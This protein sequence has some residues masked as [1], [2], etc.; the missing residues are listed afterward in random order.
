LK[1]L[2]DAVAAGDPIHAVICGSGINQD[3]A[4]NGIT[5]PNGAAQEK[6]IS[7]VYRKFGIDP[8]RIGYVE[9]HGTGTRLG[10][11]VEANA[12]IRAFRGFTSKQGYCALG[13]AK[14]HIGHTAAA[15]GV[16]GLIKVILSL[17][18]RRIPALPGLETVNPLIE[19]EGSPFR[20]NT[21]DEEWKSDGGPRMAALNSFGHSG[22]NAHLVIRE[23]PPSGAGASVPIAEHG[24]LFPLSAKTPEQLREKAL[25]LLDWLR[26]PELR[27][28]AAGPL[29]VAYT[30]QTGREPMEERV[31]FI[32][33]SLD[34]LA[35]KL[36]AWLEGASGLE[37][38][39]RGTVKRKP[40]AVGLFGQD[41]E[42]LEAVGKWIA[43]NKLSKL[44][45]LWV[46]G[47][48]LDWDPLYPGS[49][50][51][52]VRL[53]TYPFAQERY[54]VGGAG[55][56]PASGDAGPMAP[57]AADL[58]SVEDILKDVDEDAIGTEQAS[59]L[60]KNLV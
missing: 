26:S 5:A 37:G 45:E 43:R 50:P 27:D 46:Q 6:L 39:A 53:P 33:D 25:G 59:I 21:R 42:L 1:R 57:A 60:I 41:E 2:E 51:R 36:Q 52:K 49:R 12:L 34:Q 3:G 44:L 16:L 17:R 18:H 54:W 47:L 48:D 15:A 13:T 4:S 38:S 28:P 32:A 11:P 10:D 14:A 55:T 30:L 22:T 56:A 20:I 8:A 24:A 31:G 19:L 23:Y 29:E 40:E 9:A 7:A 58:G 35:D